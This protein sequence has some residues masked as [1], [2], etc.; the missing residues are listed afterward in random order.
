VGLLDVIGFEQDLGDIL[1]IQVEATSERS[2][3]PVIK[4]RVLAEAVPLVAGEGGPSTETRVSPHP[5][6]DKPSHIT[7][8][9]D[10]WQIDRGIG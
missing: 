2:L 5:K 4:D 7:A 9:L 10:S 8:T 1:G 3:H 6:P